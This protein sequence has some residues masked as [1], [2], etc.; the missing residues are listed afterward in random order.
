MF[1]GRHRHAIDGK[2]RLSVPARF[3]EALAQ[4]EGEALVV[5]PEINERCLE[6]HPLEEWMRL[7]AKLQEQP[8][9]DANARDASRLYFSRA[10]QISLDGAGRILLPPDL[11]AAVELKKDVMVVGGFLPYF[12]VWDR[13]RFE[14]FDRD[15]KARKQ[16]IQSSLAEKGV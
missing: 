15:G 9:F 6:V 10:H 13:A 4:Y 2:G 8:R 3:R 14:E 12:E 5:V 1:L 11:R 7:G 16:E